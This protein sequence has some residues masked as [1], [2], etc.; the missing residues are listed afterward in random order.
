MTVRFRTGRSIP[1]CLDEPGIATKTLVRWLCDRD[2]SN[3]RNERYILRTFAHDAAGKSVQ[4]KSVS[5]SVKN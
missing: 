5:F 2:T 3:V 4:S 1:G